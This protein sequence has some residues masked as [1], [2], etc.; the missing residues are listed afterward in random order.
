MFRLVSLLLLIAATP[1]LQAQTVIFEDDFNGCGA[2]SPAWTVTLN[3]NPNFVWYVGTPVNPK[4]DSSTI[5]GTCMLVM[6][7]DA[8]GNNTPA[9]V[10]DFQTPFF[11]VRGYASVVLEVDVHYRDLGN[12]DD[13][14]ELWLTDG[15]QQ[16]LLRRYAAGSQTGSKFSQ[17]VHFSSDLTL[18]SSADSLRVIFRYDD[19]GGYAWWAGI[20][21][22]RITGIGQGSPVIAERFDSCALP[23][24]WTSE[25]VTGDYDWFY[26]PPP[27]T[28]YGAGSSMNGS[29]FILFDDDYIGQNAKPSLLRLYTPWFDGR[30]YATFELSFE[31]IFRWYISEAFSIY[32]ETGTGER[33]LVA[34]WT[35]PVGGPSFASFLRQRF[36]LSAYRNPQ[37]RVVFEYDDGGSWG[38]W[39]GIDNVKITGNGE[40]HDLCTK[41][42]DLQENQGCVTGENRTAMFEGPVPDCS[43]INSSGIWYRWVALQSGSMAIDM[44][45]DFNDVVSVFSGDCID[46]QWVA[47][48]NRD[49][50]GFRGETTYFQAVEGTTYWIR[51][52]G[53]IQEGFGTPRG[54][55]CLRLSPGEPPQAGPNDPCLNAIPLA[56]NQDC[57]TGDNRHAVAGEAYPLRDLR[58]D[59]DVWYSF[60][61]PALQADEVLRIETGAGFSDVITVY[62]GS[63]QSPAE[64]AGTAYGQ[65]LEVGQLTEGQLYYL[66]VAG[67]FATIEGG[68]CIKAHIVQKAD[69]PVNPDCAQAVNLYIGSDCTQGTLRGAAFS[70][71]HP[72]CVLSTQRDVWFAFVAPESG[73]VQLVVDADFRQNATIWSGSCGNLEA[74]KCVRNPL[75]CEGYQKISGLTAGETYFVQVSA[76]GEERGDFCIRLLDGTAQ[77][78]Y[79]PLQ[80]TVQNLCIGIDS[81]LL[82]VNAY[83][84]VPPYTWSGTPY[85]QLLYTGETYMVVVRDAHGCEVAVSGVAP[86]C[87][88]ATSCAMQMQTL[89]V[90]PLCADGTDGAITALPS[91]GTGPYLYVWSVPGQ[92]D[93]SLQQLGSGIYTVTVYDA[94]G[95]STSASATLQSPLPI[96]ITIDTLIT[97]TGGLQDGRIEATVSGGTGDLEVT[98]L[99]EDG[100]VVGQS[101]ILTEAGRGEYTIRVTD[102]NGCTSVQTVLLLATGIEPVEEKINLVQVVPN[103]A[104]DRA[105]ILLD[106]SLPGNAVVRITDP[107]GRIVLSPR[108]RE[109]QQG[110]VAL[111]VRGFPAGTYFVQ[112]D[113]GGKT[114]TKRLLIARD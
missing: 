64:I 78:P 45:A 98:W 46:P 113:I 25:V 49:K 67:N 99:D 41:A 102:A 108:A 83:N 18:F 2:L 54:T 4:S 92:I 28:R 87:E 68:F 61:A 95:C 47:C 74:V 6:D 32:V 12:L 51:I 30:E 15:H 114:F 93:S 71:I 84:G 20:D 44:T 14:F 24:G 59:A 85:Q 97:P 86:V 34:S 65:D 88:A 37:M 104:K 19:D 63:C 35:G 31:L 89:A 33:T 53:G 55:Y 21:N 66:Q 43:E 17:F 82:L 70:G 8:T 107:A 23:A 80:L 48:G 13:A 79:D 101:A 94:N 50:Y 57:M 100:N 10:A 16:Y 60:T 73:S 40:A 69:P 58:A 36:D 103:P 111:D 27:S 56:I 106:K 38:W 72:P 52:S 76:T 39:V 7:D 29:C 75:R 22:V 77:A 112:V 3:G 105:F 1:F 26:I 81:S 109:V 42:I 96:T 62:E 11:D 5:D 91:N 9:I 110:Q 90:D